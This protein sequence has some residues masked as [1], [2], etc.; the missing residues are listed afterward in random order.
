MNLGHF[1]DRLQEE[2]QKLEKEIDHYQKED[3]YKSNLRSTEVLDDAITEIEEHDRLVATS[4]QLQEDLKEV[5]VA[6]ARLE[7]GQYGV[8]IS[9]G[10]KIEDERLEAMPTASLCL[11]CQKKL[12]R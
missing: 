8:C 3:P 2:K 10:Q 4:E 11:A 7:N 9:C 5:V 12:K 1:K 6:L